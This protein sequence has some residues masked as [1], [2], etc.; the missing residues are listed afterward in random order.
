[1][2]DQHVAIR[3]GTDIAFLGGLIRHVIET[4]AYFREYV[5]PYTNAATIIDERFRDVEDLDGVFSG[6][7][8]ATGMYDGS[9]WNYAG[10]DEAEV[11]AGWRVHATQAF[12][13]HTGAGMRLEGL[14]RDETLQHPRCVFQIL[15]RHFSATRR[16]R[17][18]ALAASRARICWRWPTR[19]FATRDA[20]APLPTATRSD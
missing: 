20:T 13:E 11:A 17:S 10:C 5:I 14:E 4:E 1:M 6:L 19:S 15:K 7:D 3:P 12:S 9:S 8:P 16:R 18:R 2:A